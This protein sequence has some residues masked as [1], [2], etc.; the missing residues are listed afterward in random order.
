M[1]RKAEQQGAAR[2]SAV[3]AKGAFIQNGRFYCKFLAASSHRIDAIRWRVSVSMRISRPETLIAP[4]GSPKLFN[5][6]AA[7]HTTP[8]SNSHHQMRSL[9]QQQCQVLPAVKTYP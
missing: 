4:I 8:L 7:T 3:T 2:I 6:G 9:F 1:L 5:S